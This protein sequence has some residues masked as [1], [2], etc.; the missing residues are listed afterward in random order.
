M[1]ALKLKIDLETLTVKEWFGWPDKDQDFILEMVL[2]NH[3][4]LKEET[5]E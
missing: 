4:I 5:P 1:R 3:L 2:S